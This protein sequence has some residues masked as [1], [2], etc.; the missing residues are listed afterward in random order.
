[1]TET[2]VAI[3]VIGIVIVIVVAVASHQARLKRAA[4]IRQLAGSRGW[5]Y[6]ER[7]DALTRRW[8]GKPFTGG[9]TATNIVTGQYRGL[10]F[11]AFTYTYTTTS[12][13]GTTTT[14]QSH[15]F[16]VYTVKLPAAVPNFSVGREGFFGGKVAE[17]FGFERVNIDDEDFNNTYKVKSDDQAFGQRI[18]QPPL[19]QL[20][21][22]SPPWDWRFTGQTMISYDAGTFEPG[23]VAPRLDRMRAVLDAIPPEVWEPSGPSL[24]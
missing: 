24:R 19:V 2:I 11:T 21:K 14:T 23:S 1:M 15:P 12:Y 17:A 13:N 5:T 18:M 20:L 8:E 16:A 9:G 22:S 4:E 3:M 6:L 10:D 7:D